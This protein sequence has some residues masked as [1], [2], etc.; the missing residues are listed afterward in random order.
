MS[1]YLQSPP[2]VSR[3]D[4]GSEPR[5]D[6][7]Q[8][9]EP[10]LS[11]ESAQGISSSSSTASSDT[12]PEETLGFPTHSLQKLNDG[13]NR[14]NWVVHIACLIDCERAAANLIKHPNRQA[15]PSPGAAACLDMASTVQQTALV[16]YKKCLMLFERQMSCMRV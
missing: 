9:P 11:S 10:V 8:E 5:L 1:D 12:E 2:E 7:Y 14:G 15:T 13:L 6:E 3:S 4:A 16:T